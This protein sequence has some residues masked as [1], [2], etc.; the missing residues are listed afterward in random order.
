M[1]GCAPKSMKKHMKA[2]A[3]GFKKIGEE[4][5]DIKKEL[6]KLKKRDKKS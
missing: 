2:D 1:K 6:G 4:A 5:K 3:K